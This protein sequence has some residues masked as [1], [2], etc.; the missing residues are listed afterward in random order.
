MGGWEGKEKNE[1]KRGDQE[2]LSPL[3]PLLLF[4]LLSS[5]LR[6]SLSLS[7]PL[8]SLPILSSN[9]SSFLCQGPYENP[10]HPH[11]STLRKLMK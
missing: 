2:I 10:K 4:T 6:S 7:S 3:S 11:G 8:L 9:G 1:K 5:P